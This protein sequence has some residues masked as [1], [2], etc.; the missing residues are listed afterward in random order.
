MSKTLLARANSLFPTGFLM[1]GG[2]CW[3]Q[4]PRLAGSASGI[5][6]VVTGEREGEET[7]KHSP[8]FTTVRIRTFWWRE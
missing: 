1:H 5:K 2:G 7:E 8:V 3:K 4:P 6:E